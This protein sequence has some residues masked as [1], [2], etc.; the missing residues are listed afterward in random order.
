MKLKRTGAFLLSGILMCTSPA[1]V[2]ADDFSEILQDAVT[3]ETIDSLLN[4][5]DMVVD[6]IMYVKDFI[7]EQDI[8]DEDIKNVIVKAADHFEV[9]LSDSDMDTILEIVKKFKNVEVDRE[10][11]KKDVEKIY[12]AMNIFGV[13]SEDVKNIFDKAVDF[14]TSILGEFK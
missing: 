2:F 1:A 5:P 4:D 12:K 7:D 6:I 10:K 13:D 14:V 9:Q 3:E 8:T 11:L